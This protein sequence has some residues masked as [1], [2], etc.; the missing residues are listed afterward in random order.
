VITL[1]HED[2]M[3]ES[4]VL[5]TGT[6][7]SLLRAVFCIVGMHF[8]LRGGQEHRD[9]K[10]EQFQRYPP[11]CQVYDESVYYQYVEHGSKNYQGRYAETGGR[12]KVVKAFAQPLS[13]KCP[14]RLLD[15][16]LSKLPA[17]LKAS[18]LQWLPK[19]KHSPWFKVTSV[20]VNPLKN[21]LQSITRLAGI[22]MQYTN[23]SL[24]VTVATRMFASGIP[25][26]IIAEVTGHKS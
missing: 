5:G 4:G 13:E 1:D 12:N 26:K 16:Y 14:V 3:W 20:G 8:C 6:P 23:H 17:S 10:V 18:Y 7:E 24:C 15:L 22:K 11:D 19:K 21:M 2:V 9:L 25:E